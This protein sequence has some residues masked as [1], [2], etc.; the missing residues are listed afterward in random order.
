MF[1]RPEYCVE[2]PSTEFVIHALRIYVFVKQKHRKINRF[3]SP[4]IWLNVAQ[5]PA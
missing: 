5:L 1:S 2:A 3:Q 4:V